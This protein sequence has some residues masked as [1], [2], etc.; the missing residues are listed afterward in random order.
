MK[1]LVGCPVLHREWILP[2]WFAHVQRAFEHL[3]ENNAHDWELEF[4]FV[5]DKETDRETYDIAVFGPVAGVHW[6]DVLDTR[7]RDEREWNPPRYQRMVDL[8]NELLFEVRDLAP[9]L[10][11]SLDSDILLHPQALI[12]MIRVLDDEH[13][14]ENTKV[15][16]GGKVYLSQYGVECP[17]WANIGRDGSIRRS[18][19]SGTFPVDVIMAVKL[20]T[21]AA[22]GVDYRF[23]KQGEDTGWSKAARESGVRL[24]WTGKVTSKHVFSRYRCGVDGHG[25]FRGTCPQD[26]RH[27]QPVSGIDFR[28]SR[29]GW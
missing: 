15:A 27:D 5:G 2:S 3:Q 8:R 16:V 4:I 1:L 6:I 12:E 10:F 28:D 23:D 14:Y 11:L 20:M 18:N 25:L 29:V 19:S 9:D 17:S 24:V 21:P 7:Q 13:A 26:P 22:Y